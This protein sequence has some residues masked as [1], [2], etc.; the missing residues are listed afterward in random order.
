MIFQIIFDLI[1]D[2]YFPNRVELKHKLQ[3][4][5][6]AVMK[7]MEAKLQ[8]A[9][10]VMQQMA[11]QYNKT[12]EEYTKKINTVDNVIRENQTLKEMLANIESKKIE[13]NKEV[14]KKIIPPE[15]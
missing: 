3:Q 15:K 12:M 11:Q 2:G 13:K 5:T 6:L 8:Q 1:P 4:G 7:Q 10:Q 14:A 9:E